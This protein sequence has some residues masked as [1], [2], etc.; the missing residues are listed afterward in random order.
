MKTE[1]R[2]INILSAEDF[3][4]I[5]KWSN[6]IQNEKYIKVNFG[7]KPYEVYE[8]KSLR[9]SFIMSKDVRYSFMILADGVRA[10]EISI[11]INPDHLAKNEEDTAWIGIQIGEEKYKGYGLGRK[12]M[13]FIEGYCRKIKISRIELGVF[14]YNERAIHLYESLGYEKFASFNDFTYC[15]GKWHTDIRMEKLL[16]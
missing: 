2:K 7:E 6:D 16:K 15:D 4:L 8:G 13:E 1:F 9:E 12:A 14:E 5:A 11:I 10:G 3:N